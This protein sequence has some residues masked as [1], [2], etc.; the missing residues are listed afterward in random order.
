MKPPPDDVVRRARRHFATPKGVGDLA[1]WRRLCQFAAVRRGGGDLA[2]YRKYRGYGI[3]THASSP[4]TGDVAT[5]WR[6]GDLAA[7]WKSS[8]LEQV[9]RNENEE[10][11]EAMDSPADGVDATTADAAPDLGRGIVGR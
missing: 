2:I 6:S 8:H 5:W 11:A 3:A 1:I 10:R 7:D 4:P 9:Y